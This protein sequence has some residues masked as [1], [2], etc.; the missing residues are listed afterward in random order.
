DFLLHHSNSW[1]RWNAVVEAGVDYFLRHA[2]GGV[3]SGTGEGFHLDRIAACERG[4]GVGAGRWSVVGDSVG[5]RGGKFLRLLSRLGNDDA[6]G[7]C[8][9]HEHDGLGDGG[10]NAGSGGV[11]VWTGG[12][13]VPGP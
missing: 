13:W 1:R 8:L 4:C 5:I 3:D 11:R 10:G 6:D 9:L 12:G 7:C 2:G